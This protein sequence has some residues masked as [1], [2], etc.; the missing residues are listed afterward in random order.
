MSGK[1]CIMCRKVSYPTQA[2]AEAAAL[3]VSVH[4]GP[5]RCYAC[6]HNPRHW[7]L[8]TMR[9]WKPPREGRPAP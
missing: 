9:R 1:R 7:H 4:V 3:R 5:V 6:P 8:T 2:A